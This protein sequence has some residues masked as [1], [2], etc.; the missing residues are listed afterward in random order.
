MHRSVP[1]LALATLLAACQGGETTDVA[2]A[3]ACLDY[4]RLE[5]AMDSA[6]L[7]APELRARLRMVAHR[8]RRADDSL[9]KHDARALLRTV[10]SGR[11]KL[12]YDSVAA[13]MT[14]AC[15]AYAE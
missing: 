11:G 1:V 4:A 5:Q 10:A 9:V 6:T 15:M 3:E 13:R 14:V 7:R 8:A 2:A 12:A